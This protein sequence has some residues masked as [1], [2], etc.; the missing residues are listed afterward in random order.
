MKFERVS[1]I[2]NLPKM[3]KSGT[4]SMVV[5]EHAM[6]CPNRAA[7]IVTDLVKG[8][9][10]MVVFRI[11]QEHATEHEKKEAGRIEDRK[12]LWK[13]MGERKRAFTKILR[14]QHERENAATRK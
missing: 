4:C 14:E 13:T 6:R 7:Y 10:C 12:N 2:N 1:V 5:G 8:K 11:C 3:V 9:N